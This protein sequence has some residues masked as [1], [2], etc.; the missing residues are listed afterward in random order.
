[1]YYAFLTPATLLLIVTSKRI[2]PL[3]IDFVATRDTMSDGTTL[4]VLG[5]DFMSLFTWVEISIVFGPF[6]PC[7]HLRNHFS[8]A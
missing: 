5:E 2:R 8:Q 4:V 1:M 7:V 3:L 6:C